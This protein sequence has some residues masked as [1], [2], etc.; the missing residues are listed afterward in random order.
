MRQF[1]NSLRRA[2]RA[3]QVIWI[4]GVYVVSTS[5]SLSTSP[6]C[7]YREGSAFAEERHYP[8]NGITESERLK[9]FQINAIERLSV[10]LRQ[11]QCVPFLLVFCLSWH[12][13]YSRAAEFQG[14]RMSEL[15]DTATGR[16][17]NE[18]NNLTFRCCGIISSTHFYNRFSSVYTN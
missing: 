18:K 1:K 7:A 12:A 10:L 8:M 9:L 17:T 11:L 2:S 5:I 4:D 6:A 3:H 15:R 14:Q 16:Q 13:V